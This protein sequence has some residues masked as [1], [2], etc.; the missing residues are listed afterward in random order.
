[1]LAILCLV[2][3]CDQGVRKKEAPRPMVN[4][5]QN[6]VEPRPDDLVRM[7]RTRCFG[8]CAAYHVVVD[9]DGHVSFVGTAFVNQCEA[10][11]VLDGE[12]LQ[13]LKRLFDDKSF[14]TLNDAYMHADVT[15]M[16]RA[17][18]FYQP[19]PGTSKR[20]LHYEGDESAP[21]RLVEIE[22]EVDRILGTA[23]W[24]TIIPR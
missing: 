6:T 16:P 15:D 23:R 21:A 12:Q 17:D 8:A 24:T 2:T 11:D 14:F 9:H 20:I 1:M 10:S 13:R 5:P 18:L 4:C 7:T 22:D 19:K 3:A